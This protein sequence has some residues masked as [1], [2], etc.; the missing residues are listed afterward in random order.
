MREKIDTE[1]LKGNLYEEGG[2]WEIDKEM[3]GYYNGSQEKY[4]RWENV[5]CIKTAPDRIHVKTAG[6]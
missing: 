5:N 1:C 3:R 6:V 4:V 2:T